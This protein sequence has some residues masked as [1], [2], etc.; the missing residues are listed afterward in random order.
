M[1]NP[2]R[3]PGGKRFLADYIANLIRVNDLVG[4]TIHEPFAGSAA[5]SLDLLDRDL[6]E[7]AVLIEKDP[8]IYSFWK[9]VVEQPE[10]L[11]ARIDELTISID[12]WHALSH[13]RTIVNPLG[14]TLQL[15]LAG[16]FF[17]RTNYSG[18]LMANP[19]GGKAQESE[20]TLDCRFKKE[21]VKEQIMLVARFRNRITVEW[22][23]AKRYLRRERA[24]ITQENHFVYVDPPYYEK[25]QSLYRFHFQEDDHRS[26]AE[27]LHGCHFPWLLSYDNHPFIQDLYFGQAAIP[28]HHHEFFVDSFI[29]SRT[30][31]IELLISNLEIPPIERASRAIQAI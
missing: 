25:G 10:E 11:C 2:L 8:L 17:N 6:V 18:I 1:T 22:I 23:D 31:G 19:L 13:L 21:S 5:V 12:T 3:Y 29:R 20:Y 7:R 26:L 27:L 16:L 9:S 30:R 28:P 4:T 24:N 15:G 14:N